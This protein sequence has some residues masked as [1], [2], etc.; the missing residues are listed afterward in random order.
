MGDAVSTRSP[1]RYVVILF[2]TR[3]RKV[4]ATVAT[5][6]VAGIA[7]LAFAAFLSDVEGGGSGYIGEV[8]ALTFAAGPIP[9]DSPLVP[10]VSSDASVT[11]DAGNAPAGLEVY[12]VQAAPG[13]FVVNGFGPVDASGRLAVN[14]HVLANPIPVDSGTT[15]IRVPNTFTATSA[16]PTDWRGHG[17]SKAVRLRFRAP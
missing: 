15:T 3:K 1:R 4:L 11:V 10:G 13:D 5:C 14:D 16:L 7:T 17:F 2:N 6:A 8:N 9:T 12:E